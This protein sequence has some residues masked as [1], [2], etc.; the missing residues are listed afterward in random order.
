MA[1]MDSAGKVAEFHRA[2][3]A[4]LEPLRNAKRAAEM[5][6]YMRNQFE[7]IGVGTPERRAAVAPLIRALK[8][9]D[10]A[11]LRRAAD[12][13]WRMRERDYQYVAVGLLGRYQALLSLD[14]LPWLL[15]LVQEKSWWDT[16]DSLVKAVGPVVE[17]AGAK[18]K[19][20]MDAAV[21]HENFW[22][23]RIAMLHQLGLRGETDTKRLFGYAERLAPE[24]EFFIRKAI[25]WALRDY[26]W[27]DWRAVE[28]FLKKT[29]VQFSGLTVREASKNFAALEKRG[30]PV[31]SPR[32]RNG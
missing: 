32:G 20:A 16:V 7:Y 4:A 6:A 9:A 21:K 8:P 26:A 1:R 10:A 18:G 25:G 17:R 15:D 2:V 30:R 31:K 12:G 13:L 27:H 29:R 19:R 3:R 5:S 22:V 28:S 11:E 23:R 14:D 24:G